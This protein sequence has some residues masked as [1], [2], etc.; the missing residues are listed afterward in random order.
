MFLTL[1][2]ECIIICLWEG[3]IMNYRLLLATAVC[4]IIAC[5]CATAPAVTEDCLLEPVFFEFDQSSLSI[6]ARQVLDRNIEC[7]Q[8]H[9]EATIEISGHTDERGTEEYNISLGLRLAKSVER[10]LVK[11]AGITKSRLMTVSFGEDRPLCTDSNERC[12]ATN[13][14]VELRFLTE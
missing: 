7:I 1:F 9:P 3:G 13:R 11:A 4:V 10:Y 2:V 6:E 12:W 8:V 14:R 5:S